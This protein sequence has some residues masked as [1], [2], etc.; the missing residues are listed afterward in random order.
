MGNVPQA[1]AVDLADAQAVQAVGAI[2]QA[3]HLAAVADS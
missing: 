3:L 1:V 2:A